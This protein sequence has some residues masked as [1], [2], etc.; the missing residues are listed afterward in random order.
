[1]VVAVALARASS[2]VLF[3]LAHLLFNLIV[4]QSVCLSLFTRLCP[5]E[6]REL[7]LIPVYTLLCVARPRLSLLSGVVLGLMTVTFLFVFLSVVWMNSGVVDAWLSDQLLLSDDPVLGGVALVVA[8]AYGGLSHMLPVY[9]PDRGQISFSLVVAGGVVRFLVFAAVGLCKSA[10]LSLFL[11]PTQNLQ[12]PHPPNYLAAAYGIC[13]VV[14][15]MHMASA[16]FEQLK[17]LTSLLSG[18]TYTAR[19]LIRLQ[20]ILNAGL[21]G[22]AWAFPLHLSEL[23]VLVAGVL[24]C[25]QML[26]SWY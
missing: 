12:Y 8:S 20:H 5:P 3:Q 4:S 21:V 19:R 9:A 15:C 16:W 6:G 1:L 7:A 22:A 11:S 23:R 14:S 17:T 13:L 24:L 18:Q 25:L 2:G 26:F 10:L